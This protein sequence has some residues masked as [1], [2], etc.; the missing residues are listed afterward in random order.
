MDTSEKIRLLRRKYGWTK[1]DLAEKIGYSKQ[2]VSSIE[3]GKD[4]YPLLR[5]LA[6]VLQCSCGELLDDADGGTSI[7]T[8]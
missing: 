3:R 4:C 7:K 1:E 5:Q 2:Y 8:E 6:D